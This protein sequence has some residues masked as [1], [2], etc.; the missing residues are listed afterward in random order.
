[1]F[2]IMEVSAGFSFEAKGAGDPRRSEGARVGRADVE[3]QRPLPQA[4]PGEKWLVIEEIFS[5]RAQ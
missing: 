4:K 1:M 3:F 5:L 2:M